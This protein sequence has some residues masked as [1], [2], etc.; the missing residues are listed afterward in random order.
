VA[1]FDIEYGKKILEDQDTQDPESCFRQIQEMEMVLQNSS[2]GHE[3]ALIELAA[4]HD[5]I[6]L[7]E[8]HHKLDEFKKAYFQARQ[9][10]FNHHPQRLEALEQELHLQKNQVFR[11]FHA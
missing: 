8:I 6:Q 1:I 9:Y 10:L 7:D 11:Q 4:T 5:P 3:Y 2:Y